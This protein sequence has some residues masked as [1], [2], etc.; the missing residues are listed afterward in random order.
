MNGFSDVGAEALGR[1][2]K[3]NRTLMELDVS[4][5][6]ISEIGAGHIALGLQTNDVLKC[7][8]VKNIFKGFY[9]LLYIIYKYKGKK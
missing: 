5:N 1:A 8:K 9:I 7:L 3:H 4:H 2:L 6:R